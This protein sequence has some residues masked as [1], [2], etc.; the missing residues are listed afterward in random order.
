MTITQLAV[1]PRER[2]LMAAQKE[3]AAF[4]RRDREFIKKQKRE[5]AEE[6]Q[7]PALKTN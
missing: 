5:R 7:M 6:L 3:L 2:F 1:T 4:E